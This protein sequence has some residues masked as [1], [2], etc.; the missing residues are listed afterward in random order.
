M[1][2]IEELNRFANRCGYFYNA[3]LEK[4]ISVNNGYNCRHPEQ[5]EY[6]IEDGEKIGSCYC[7]SCPLAYEADEEDFLNPEIDN[8]GYEF[9]EME[10]V[11]FEESEAG[12]KD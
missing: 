2:K 4:D 9:E 8:Q 3:Y 1:R 11:V 6:E 10:F 12:G 5:E 7:W